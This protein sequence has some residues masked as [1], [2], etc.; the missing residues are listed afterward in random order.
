MFNEIKDESPIIV[1][2]LPSDIEKGKTYIINQSCP[3]NFTHSYFKYP[4]KFI[5]EIPRWAINTYLEG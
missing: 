2:N 5:P 4:C 3:N 1:E